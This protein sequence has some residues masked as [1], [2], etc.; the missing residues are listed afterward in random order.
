M[1]MRSL[2]PWGRSNDQQAPTLYRESE[3]N[4]FLSLQRD[5]NRL[6][7][8]VFRSFGSRSPS[9]GSFASFEPWPSVE[10]SE[11]EKEIRVTADVPGLE[12]NDIEVL[13]DCNL[14]DRAR[15]AVDWL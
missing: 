2:I 12:E 3:Q 13:L 7:D 1:N 10:I 8:D 9:L 15:H 6:F 14:N 5:M 11:T 4:P